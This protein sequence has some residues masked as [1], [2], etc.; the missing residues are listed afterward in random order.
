[1]LHQRHPCHGLTFGTQSSR[2]SLLPSSTTRLSLPPTSPELL[3]RLLQPPQL[4][5]PHQLINPQYLRL[6]LLPLKRYLVALF[7]R[8]PE[9]R[10]CESVL[11]V[12]PEVIHPSDGEGEVH[13][14]LWG[15]LDGRGG[16]GLG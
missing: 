14:E 2:S 3:L 12:R 8:G 1:M 6:D 11:E 15:V 7:L 10:D 16:G 9:V 4:P 5:L 13:P